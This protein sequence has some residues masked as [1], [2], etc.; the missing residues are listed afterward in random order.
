VIRTFAVAVVAVV[1]AK[2]APAM[3]LEWTP[4]DPPG[5]TA[6]ALVGDGTGTI[7]VATEGGGVFRSTDEGALW[8]SVSAGLGSRATNALVRHSGGRLW[9]GTEAGPFSSDDL[10][11]SWTVPGVALALPVEGLAWDPRP[12]RWI[13]AATE[14]G[15]IM[16]LADDGTWSVDDTALATETVTAIA[17][18]GD[19][20]GYA[21][22]DGGSWFRDELPLFADGFESGGTDAWAVV[23]P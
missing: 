6:V 22:G 20:T 11:S 16:I 1:L 8:V 15:G 14:G 17:F 2:V 4:S 3:A 18:S 7:W 10:G 19:T 21:G 9:A 12:D 23:S 13:A 5:G